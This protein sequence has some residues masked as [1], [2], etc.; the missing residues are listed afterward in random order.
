MGLF[1]FT[2]QEILPDLTGLKSHSDKKLEYHPIQ[3]LFLQR[4]Q[5]SRQSMNGDEFV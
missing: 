4:L 3:R 1:I 2:H 5:K